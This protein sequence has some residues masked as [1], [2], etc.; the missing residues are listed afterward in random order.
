MLSSSPREGAAVFDNVWMEYFC[1]EKLCP[2]QSNLVTENVFSSLTWNVIQFIRSDWPGFIIFQ[3]WTFL[4]KLLVKSLLLRKWIPRGREG[5]EWAAHGHIFRR[6]VKI[7]L[8]LYF[9]RYFT[10]YHHCLAFA[11]RCFL[12]TMDSFC[13]GVN[14]CE[15][16][17]RLLQSGVSVCGFWELPT[18]FSSSLWCLTDNM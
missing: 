7:T 11:S 13:P 14:P 1:E 17:H 4:W 12:K 16:Q 15:H 5:C 8:S 10:P 3:R 18:S 6:I 9:P 2:V